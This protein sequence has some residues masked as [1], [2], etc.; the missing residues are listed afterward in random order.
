VHC[1]FP[2]K[3]HQKYDAES[4]PQPH[5]LA[6]KCEEHTGGAKKRLFL[7]L[8]LKA[9]GTSAWEELLNVQQ[10]MKAEAD[11]KGKMEA[12]LKC[13]GLHITAQVRNEKI[14][15]KKYPAG[16]ESTPRSE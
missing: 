7:K 11:K 5:S 6:D 13:N 8:M 4:K 10:K 9:A 12:M 3:C 2:Q 14:K 16:N 1:V 15:R